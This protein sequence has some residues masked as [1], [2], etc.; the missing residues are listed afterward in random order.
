MAQWITA[1]RSWLQGPVSEPAMVAISIV[2]D[3]RKIYGPENDL[4]VPSLLLD[5]HPRDRRLRLLLR[6]ALST[7]PPTGFLRDIVVEHS[8]EHAG[9]FDIKHGGLLP[10]VN[11]AR[12]F[13]LE[14]RART[15]STT[16]RL[17]AAA[18]AG[19]VSEPDAA[20]LEEAFELF[21]ELR[22]DHQVRQIE[23]GIPPDN[24]IDPKTLNA[25]NRRYLREAF[26]AVASVQRTLTTKLAWT[27]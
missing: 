9:R 2:L 16:E 22:L 11:I 15:T 8:G 5:A 27:E 20:T 1:I 17:R 12:Y 24:L 7:R 25:L 3:A 4:D 10:V 18:A 6:L 21:S 19:R 23:A 14:A 13:G 26:R